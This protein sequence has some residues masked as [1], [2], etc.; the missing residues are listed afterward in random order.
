MLHSDSN[1]SASTLLYSAPTQHSQLH[2]VIVKHT[3]PFSTNH[4]HSYA[5]L[6]SLVF[7]YTLPMLMQVLHSHTER[8]FSTQQEHSNALYYTLLYLDTPN[9]DVQCQIPPGVEKLFQ[10]NLRDS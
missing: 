2:L 6:Y 1:D 4:T 3:L 8:D 5:L 9:I 10:V 7:I